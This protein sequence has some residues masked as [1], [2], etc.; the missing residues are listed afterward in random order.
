MVF[1]Q[2]KRMIDGQTRRFD[3]R[4]CLNHCM[5]VSQKQSHLTLFGQGHEICTCKQYHHRHTLL[6]CVCLCFFVF[7]QCGLLLCCCHV[8]CVQFLGASKNTISTSVVPWKGQPKLVLRI[9]V[10]LV[11]IVIIIGIDETCHQHWDL[12]WP[13]FPFAFVYLFLGRVFSVAILW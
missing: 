6:V 3:S 12:L 8:T 13:A 10:N 9:N 5:L 7:F 1:L 4:H 11:N 2:L